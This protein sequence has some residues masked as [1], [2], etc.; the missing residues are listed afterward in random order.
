MKINRTIALISIVFAIIVICIS[1]TFDKS[2]FGDDFSGPDFFP[3]ICAVCM[4]LL[5]L[6][7]LL[8]NR[9]EVPVKNMSFKPFAV[10]I[11]VLLVL[12]VYI[13]L[14]KV[15][16]FTIASFLLCMFFLK[17][18]GVKKPIISCIFSAIAA[19]GVNFVFNDL[20]AV[21]LPEGILPP[22]SQIAALVFIALYIIVLLVL[23]FI[24]GGKHND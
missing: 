3:R 16:G 18:F 14:L 12:M 5:S 20:L 24:R 6:M 2:I 17:I 9:K 1:T 10:P 22:W 21:S 15:I 7:L 11:I 19:F 13:L 8:Q 23:K 4:I